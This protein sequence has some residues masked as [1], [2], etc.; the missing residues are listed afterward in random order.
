[1]KTRNLLAAALLA[2]AAFT[3]TIARAAEPLP[4]W[5]EGPAKQAIIEFV[6]RV[7]KEDSP[8]FVPPAERIA[9]F[10]ND[11]TLWNEK[12]LYI[13]I[14]A[15]LARYKEQ[16]TANPKLAEQQP[17][18]AV[19]K[20]D[21]GYFKKLYEDKAINELVS[22]LIGVPFEGLTP[23]QYA[24]WNR[25]WLD[26]WKHPRFD[27][28]YRGL[29][30]Q[31]MV[32]LV[33]HLKANQFKVYIFT[34]DEAAF[35]RVVSEELYGIPPENVLGSSVKL[36]FDSSTEPTKLVR[37]KEMNYLDNWD[38]KPRLIEQVIGKRP[39]LAAGNSN[40]DLEMLQYVGNQK[41]LSLALLVHHTDEKREYK[42]DTH[43]EQVL[44]AAQKGGW[45]VV[46]MARDWKTVFAVEKR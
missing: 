32:E 4:S 46:D 41:R 1:M 21:L 14:D 31:P 38:G 37:T 8:D 28:G 36:K 18:T 39:I 9:T 35:L 43:T 11:G 7:T 13:H 42:Y 17:Y 27:V 33:K 3:T 20:K 44:P 25:K 24:D 26:T 19:A 23:E 10:D 40:G 34:A 30:Y 16:L 2:A 15:L 29:T 6:A 12:P 5:N 22:D 45:T